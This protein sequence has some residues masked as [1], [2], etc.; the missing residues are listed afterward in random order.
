MHILQPRTIS[1]LDWWVAAVPR[2]CWEKMRSKAKILSW[3]YEEEPAQ[4]I[5][6]RAASSLQLEILRTS[7]DNSMREA[8][9]SFRS[10]FMNEN[11]RSCVALHGSW[12]LG[13]T[14]GSGRPPDLERRSLRT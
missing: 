1:S 11:S 8:E 3:K 13:L 7:A 12:S 6:I 5:E 4:S 2:T 14:R 9:S 10:S